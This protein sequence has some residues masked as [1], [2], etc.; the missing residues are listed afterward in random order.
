MA[1]VEARMVADV[2][3]VEMAMCSEEALFRNTT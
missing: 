3:N 1:N 2:A